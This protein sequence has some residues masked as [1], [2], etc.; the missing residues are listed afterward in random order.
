V[1]Q[2]VLD[3]S[4]RLGADKLLD[5]LAELAAWRAALEV[6]VNLRAAIAQSVLE[7][8]RGVG[9]DIGRPVLGAVPQA[10][11]LVTWSVNGDG[12]L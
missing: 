3:L 6:H 12:G 9:I 7:P 1:P 10:L 2:I 11:D 8:N 4:Q 5:D